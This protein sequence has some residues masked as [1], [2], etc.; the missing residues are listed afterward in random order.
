A[1]FPLGSGLGDTV[2]ALAVNGTDV[3]A[4][5][6]FTTAGGGPASRVAGWNGSAWF[7]L[8]GGVNNPSNTA[9]VN[10]LTLGDGGSY[11]GGSFTTAGGSPA[12]M[13]ALYQTA[14]LPTVTPG[15]SPTPTNTP[16]NTP[17][18]QP[19]ATFTPVA[20]DNPPTVTVPLNRPY[21]IGVEVGNYLALR[22][23]A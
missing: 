7:D 13:V 19:T 14:G 3:Y 1:W 8:A 16:T 12:S 17:Q 23:D 5:G 15:P 11:V 20:G 21:R 18:P 10:A 22:F 9:V 6:L 2:Y 4:G